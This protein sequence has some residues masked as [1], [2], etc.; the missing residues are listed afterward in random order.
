MLLSSRGTTILFFFSEADI[1]L[2][3][4]ITLLNRSG[5][6]LSVSWEGVPHP[7]DSDWIGVYSPPVNGGI[8]PKNH[9]PIKYQVND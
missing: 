2:K 5:D 4:N 9:A 7:S 8:D 1:V 3:V 6:W